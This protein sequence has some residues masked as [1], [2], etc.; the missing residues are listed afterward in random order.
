[1][2]KK[3][4]T[5]SSFLSDDEAARERRRTEELVR[6]IVGKTRPASSVIKEPLSSSSRVGNQTTRVDETSY[7]AV[8]YDDKDKLVLVYGKEIPEGIPFRLGF[9]QSETVGI[10]RLLGKALATIGDSQRSVLVGEKKTALLLTTME[11][12]DSSCYIKI[13]RRP[14]ASSSWRSMKTKRCG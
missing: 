8:D 5:H 1:L 3:R 14:C 12:A 6:S 10:Y 7:F 9:S 11:L 4:R 2:G 13:R